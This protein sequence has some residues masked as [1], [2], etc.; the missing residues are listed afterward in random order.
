M[1]EKKKFHFV[2]AGFAYQKG[3]WKFNS[4]TLNTMN[5]NN[6]DDTYHDTNRALH[7]VE[8]KLIHE[9]IEHFYKNH[10]WLKSSP[11]TRISRQELSQYPPLNS[12]KSGVDCGANLAM[13]NA[14]R[15]LHGTVIRFDRRRGFGFIKCIGFNK[16]IFVH[17]S[18]ILDWSLNWNFLAIGENI[19]FNIKNTYKGWQAKNVTRLPL[20]YY[21]YYDY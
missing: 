19:E 21:L 6:N 18:E 8:E 3:R 17:R 12:V 5:P 9:V 11:D 15:R 10:R 16:D 1:V 7:K 14:N 4:G 20:Y 13:V 2:G